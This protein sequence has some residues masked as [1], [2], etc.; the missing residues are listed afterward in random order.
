M[1]KR[2]VFVGRWNP[3]HKGHLEMMESKIKSGTPLLILVRD[4]HYDIYPAQLRKRMIEAAM[5]K[6]KIDA[7]VV[8]VDD[9]ESVNYGR[10][11]GYEVN[12]IAVTENVKKISGTSIRSMIE[13]G[14]RSWKK[15]MPEGADK[16]LEDYLSDSGIVVWFTGLPKSGKKTISQKVSVELENRGIR[17]EVLHG[18]ILRDTISKD[19]AFSKEDRLR[20]IQ[21]ASYITKLL[22]KNGAIVLCSFITPYNSLRSEIRKDL[23]KHATFVQ[24]YVNTSIE[25]CKKRDDEGI[26]KK[27]ESGEIPQFTGV[28]DKFEE[29][30]NSEITVNTEEKSAKECAAEIVEYIVGLI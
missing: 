30:K 25:G 20:N 4:T 6:R 27:A 1:T 29:P 2:A 3:F 14:D 7:K 24:V 10:G 26:Y 23:E 11:V 8:V 5:S 17:N 19:L 18:G 28:T 15:F 16:V 9:I 12:E 13:K 22:A 21:R